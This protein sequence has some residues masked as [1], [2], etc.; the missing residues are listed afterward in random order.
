MR[1][2]ICG[3]DDVI[4]EGNKVSLSLAARVLKRRHRERASKVKYL[5]LR[6]L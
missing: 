2:L 5:D 6:F 4:E 1:E 3:S